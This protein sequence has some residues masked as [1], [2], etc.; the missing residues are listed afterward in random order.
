MIYK[1]VYRQSECL[2]KIYKIL[3]LMRDENGDLKQP[4]ERFET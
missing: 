4:H 2:I 3:S 1:S